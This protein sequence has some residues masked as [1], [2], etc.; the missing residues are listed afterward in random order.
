MAAGLLSPFAAWFGY[1]TSRASKEIDLRDVSAVIF[2]LDG[3]LTDT[4]RI[5]AETWKQLFDEYLRTRSELDGT[6][7]LPFD[8]DT[9]YHRY[10]D[11]KARCDGVRSFLASRRISLSEGSPDDKPGSETVYGLGQQK[12]RYFVARLRTQRPQPYESSIELVERLKAGGLRTAVISASRN[13]GKVLEAAGIGGLFDVRVDGIDSDRLQLKGKPD[14]AIFLEAARRLGVK[15]EE[16]IVVED[17]LVGVEA[18]RRGGFRLVIGV[19]RASQGEELRKRGAHI[20]VSDLS[21]LQVRLL[22]SRRPSGARAIDSLPSALER[23]DEIFT[24]LHEETAAVFLDYDGTLTP[25]VED[26]A[27]ARLSESTRRVI[28]RLS[29]QYS[30]AIISGRDLADVQGM[31]DIKE[32]AY[33]GSHGFDISGPGGQYRDREK[34]TGYLPALDMAQSELSEALKDIPGAGLERKLFAIAAHYRKVDRDRLGELENRF[35]EVLSH[36]PQLRKTTGKEIFELRPNVD[37]DK[38]K[39]LLHL[40]EVLYADSSR[41]LPVY[42]GDDDTDEDA[43]RAIRDHGIGIVVGAGKRPTAARY[44]LRDTDETTQ[45]LQALVALAKAEVSR[46]IWTLAY[47]GY[48]PEQ[49][50]LRE[51][52]CTLGNGHFATRGAAPESDADNVHYP[53]TYVAGCFN[54]LKTEI[55]G[56]IIENECMVNAPNWLPLTFRIEDGEWFN[57][58]DWDILQY[59]QELDLRR[60]VLTRT[61]RV[62][63]AQGRR[64]RLVQR[65]FVSMANPHLAALETAMVA[66][67]WSGRAHVLSALNGTVTNSGV[68]RY[69]ELDSRHLQPVETR[70]VHAETTCL[71]VET[72]QSHIRIAEAARTRISIHGEPV[73]VEP[74]VTQRP[75]YIAQ[76]L[77]VDV[78][79]GKTVTVEKIVALYTSRDHAISECGD[80]A[81][82]EA[83]RSPGFTDL[84]QRHVV[85]WNH[86]WKRCQ[87]VIKGSRRVSLI[88]NLHIFH[89]LQ[90]VSP[91]T[92]EHDAGVPARGLH[93]EAYRG[94]IFW[95]ELFI[96]PFLNLRIPDITRALLLY[97]Y[98]RLPGARWAATE[99]GLEGAMYPWQSGS[100][101][102][103]ETQTLHLN[104]RSGRWL[105]DN[106]RRQRHINIAIA[107][108][109]WHYYQV[110]GDVNFLAFYGAEMLIEI[111][112]FWASIAK[113]NRSLDRYEI[114]RI[115]GPDEFHDAYPDADE[116]GI[117][118]NAYTNIMAVW[119]LCR[120]GEAIDVLPANRREALRDKL[121]LRREELERWERI[122]RKMLVVFQDGDIVSQFKGYELL[123]ELDWQGYRAKYGDIHRLDRIL[124]AEGDTPNRY[125][126]SK[127]ADVL[128]LF[129]LLSADE[130]REILHRLGYPCEYETIPR[131]IDYYLERTSH[132]STLSRVVHSWVLA[133]SKRELSWHLLKEA[134]ESDV[135]DVQGGTTR[136]G[137]HLGAMAGT[138]D[139]IQRCYTGIET[140]SDTL[141][142]NPCL[143]AELDEM[144][145][146]ITYRQ[147]RINLVLTH[148]R[149]MISAQ[150]GAA[151][152]IRVGLRDQITELKAGDTVEFD[153]HTGTD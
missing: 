56:Q 121:G 24:R 71:Q 5:H 31:V 87:I 3:V 116:P 29:E 117:D 108:N 131:N 129:Y 143:P 101:G 10:V 26:P 114:C 63:D 107:Y 72:N 15:P 11:G 150:P 76:E 45:F 92:I 37:W 82:T 75:G 38:G 98:R 47:D 137:I 68:K 51:A 77:T 122:S 148:D 34:G 61:M 54:R 127:Q 9:D 146:D 149:L 57:T 118:N 17:A 115:M 126:V 12:N 13:A 139:L 106:S 43:F 134:L 23:K 88:L 73:P 138:V 7:F 55:S 112:R 140:R 32:I 104:P 93:G 120:A 83:E 85:S 133:R 70:A 64:T 99:A 109:V 90:T 119:V 39:A 152:P 6:E 100:D 28:R 27:E 44:A 30:V 94:H 41:V 59:R 105:P 60:G 84:L 22:G 153:L 151:V 65:R 1:M 25:I 33:A 96:F 80:Q 79:Q 16:A 50:G 40:L 124:E 74:R 132:G 49:E 89:L 21:E 110:T 141:Q 95:D 142:L 113:Y 67:N 145:F 102:R 14:P 144:R 2:D 20:V 69:Q 62:A 97:R 147:H 48:D 103:E 36:Y 78:Q 130:L 111:A 8:L 19:D 18:G 42:I 91:H 4:A 86:L 35:D 125:K 128:M 58:G 123:K 81:C 135:S 136:E 52:L 46:G 53:G 66:E